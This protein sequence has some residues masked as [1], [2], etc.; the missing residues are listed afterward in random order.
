MSIAASATTQP[1]APAVSVADQLIQDVQ[2]YIRSGA[3]DN[4]QAYR[5]ALQDFRTMRRLTM[6]Q[7]RELFRACS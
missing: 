1:Q 6:R 5:A 7:A 2:A 4:A 3:M